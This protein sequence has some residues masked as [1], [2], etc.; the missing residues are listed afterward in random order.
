MRRWTIQKILV[1][2]AAAIAAIFICTLVSRAQTPVALSPVAKQQFFD[3]GGKPLAGGALFTFIA[4]TTTQQATYSESTGTTVNSNPIILDAGGFVSPGPLFLSGG[5]GYKFV[6]CAAFTGVAGTGTCATFGPQ[7]WTI[8]NILLSPFLSG[9]NTFTGNNSFNGTTTF[10]GPVNMNGGG[11]LSGTFSGSPTFSG[12]PIFSGGMTVT[13]GT[14]TSSTLITPT[15]TS[16]T[17]TTT[18]IVPNL[19][20]DRQSISIANAAAGGTILNT[21]AKLTG[22]PSTAVITQTTD[23]GGVIGVVTAGA[24]TTGNATIQTNGIA[25]CIFDGATTAGDFVQISAT[26]AGD[27]HDVGGGGYPSSGQAVG[28]VLTSNGVGGTYTMEV[29]PPDIRAGATTVFPTVVY[30]TPSASTNANIVA[31]TMAT[32]GASN[33]DYRMNF[34]LDETVVGVG[35][36]GNTTIVVIATFQDPN[37]AGPNS[38]SVQTFTIINNGSLGFQ[39]VGGVFPVRIKTGTVIQ[40]STTYSIGATCAPGPS[41]QVFPVLE[42]LT[43]N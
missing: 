2:L 20:P 21:L 4:G 1:V 34:I 3:A 6:L 27:C 19:N 28:R 36:T 26:V 7:Q 31:T 40:Y 39:Q 29:F 24:G 12:T 32:A 42:Q 11:S 5:A 14:F 38:G 33:A 9:N 10:N 35:C 16:P 41:Y 37:A 30:N 13:G 8:D 15:I 43:S 18:T 17:V 22:A 23:V 25:S